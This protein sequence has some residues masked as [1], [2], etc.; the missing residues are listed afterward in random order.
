M[1][2]AKKKAAASTPSLRA[3]MANLE[4]AAAGVQA[5]RNTILRSYS[6]RLQSRMQELL[7]RAG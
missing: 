7:G 2:C 5:H 4:K 6:E 1:R 3:R